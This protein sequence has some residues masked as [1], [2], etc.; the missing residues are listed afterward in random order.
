MLLRMYISVCFREV[1]I[2]FMFRTL[3]FIYAGVGVIVHR[4]V[5]ING[6]SS[7][8][9]LASEKRASEWMFNESIESAE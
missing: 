1:I 2:L 6:L 3:M 7:V 8:S 5:C 9:Q 4:L